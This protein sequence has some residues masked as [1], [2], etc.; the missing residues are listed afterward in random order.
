MPEML[1]LESSFEE[2]KNLPI[3]KFLVL[4]INANLE[5]FQ[6]KIKKLKFPVWIKLNTSEHKLKIGAVEQACD[7]EELKKVYNELKKKFPDS[8]FILQENAS[9]IEI[10]AG[11]KKDRTFNKVLMIGAGGS[12]AE[13]LK[14]IEFVILPAEKQEIENAL[15][16]LKISS[17]LEQKNLAIG[18]LLA[19]LLAFSQMK[20]QEAD[21]N[22]IIVNEKDALIVD[23][24]LAVEEE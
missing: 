16:Q 24:R 18:K 20:I 19:L 9:G 15:K 3:A 23:C 5:K 2:L 14:D 4:P 12:Y 11:I 21:L 17:I 8:K 1:D 22:P 7:F 6:D 10:I 13:I